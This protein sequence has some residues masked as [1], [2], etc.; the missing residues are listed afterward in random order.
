MFFHSQFVKQ[1]IMLW[2]EAKIVTYYF[3]IFSDI[4]AVDYCCPTC[5]GEHSYINQIQSYNSRYTIV[6]KYMYIEILHTSEHRNGSSF[7][8]S[9]MLHSN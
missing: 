9:V 5:R 1:H 7:S 6:C 4:V 3:H 2:A 8:S